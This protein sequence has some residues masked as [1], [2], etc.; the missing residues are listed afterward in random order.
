MIKKQPAWKYLIYDAFELTVHLYQNCLI[1]EIL[2]GLTNILIMK[3]VIYVKLPCIKQLLEEYPCLSH[4]NFFVMI[5]FTCVYQHAKFLGLYCC[6]SVIT[7][8]SKFLNLISL[9]C[10]LSE[11]F[12]MSKNRILSSRAFQ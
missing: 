1:F 3:S 5:D 10:Y 7:K 8:D 9:T 6:C 12:L 2:V 11:H 4:S